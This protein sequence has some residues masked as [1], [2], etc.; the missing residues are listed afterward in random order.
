MISI[1]IP[2]YNVEKYILK[3]LRSISS[4]T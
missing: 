3:C 2:V 4:Q 1:I